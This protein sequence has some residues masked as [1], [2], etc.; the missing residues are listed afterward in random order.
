MGWFAPY[1]TSDSHNRAIFTHP[2]VPF[3]KSVHTA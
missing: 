2:D 1:L 3:L